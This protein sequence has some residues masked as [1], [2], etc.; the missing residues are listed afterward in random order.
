VIDVL[1][2]RRSF[3]VPLTIGVIADTHIYSGSARRVPNQVINLFRRAEVGLI[4]HLGDVNSA[5]VLEELAEI[6]PVLAVVGN[7]DDDQLQDALP[8]RLQFTVG[9]HTFGAIHGDGG[10]SAKDQVKKTFGGKVDLAMFG[11]SHIPF[12]DDYK[13]TTLFN[14]G[15]ATDRRWHEHFGVGIVRVTGDQINPELILYANPEHLNNISF[16]SADVESPSMERAS[17]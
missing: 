13:G 1:E 3:D 9:N 16:E 8:T 7:N 6:A 12:I 11:H 14:P 10:R 5:W 15:S 2:K 4:I 17:S